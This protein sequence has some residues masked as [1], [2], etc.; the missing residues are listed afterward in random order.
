MWFCFSLQVSNLKKESVF[1]WFKEDTQIVPD[2]KPDLGSG[3][4]KLPIKLVI[5]LWYC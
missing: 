4:C 5:L 2:V 1:Q 3:L